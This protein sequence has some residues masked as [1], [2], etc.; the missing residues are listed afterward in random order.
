MFLLAKKSSTWWN[1]NKQQ[2]GQLKNLQIINIKSE[3]V[4]AMQDLVSRNMAL[5]ITIQ[6][7][8]IWL[9]DSSQ[10]ISIEIFI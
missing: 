8:I 10:S 1:K 7:G 2:Y 6:E 9:S 3:D 5:Q 4:T